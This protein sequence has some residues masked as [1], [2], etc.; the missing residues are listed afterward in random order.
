VEVSRER[1]GIGPEGFVVDFAKLKDEVDKLVVD[2]LDHTL[3]NDLM[4]EPTCEYIL[5]WIW[6]TLRSNSELFWQE[7]LSLRR[8]RLQETP[9]SFAELKEGFY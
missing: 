2:K 6:E 9:G 1:G 7:G 5:Q 3:L 8:V 4:S